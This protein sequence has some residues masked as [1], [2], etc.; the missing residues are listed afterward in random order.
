[1]FLERLRLDG[2]VS[3]VTGGGQGGIGTHTCLALAEAGSKVLVLD[4]TVELAAETVEQI[5]KAG[6]TAEALKV[7][8]MVDSD[9]DRVVP[10]VMERFGR[11]D[12]LVNVAGGATGVAKW[13]AIED[14][15]LD[16][17]DA[18]HQL[19]LRY[20]FQLGRQVAKQMI[21]SGTP[22][23]IVNISSVAASRVSRGLVAYAVAKAGLSHLT[24]AMALEWGPHRIRVNGVAPGGVSSPR[25]LRARGITRM[26]YDETVGPDIPLQ[27]S[28]YPEDIA[29]AVLFLV[30]DLASYVSGHILVVDGASTVGSSS[31]LKSPESA[32]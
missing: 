7:D 29:G 16:S 25:V 30:S 10:E 11:V 8:V 3:V 12:A 20:V 31:T 23:S 5:R 28:A 13:G 26:E 1:M 6:G 24:R 27:R 4:R 19:N 2:R 14:Y 15:D 18:L 32:R 17:W 22:G 9:L 21:S